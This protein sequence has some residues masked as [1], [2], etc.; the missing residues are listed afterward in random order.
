MNHVFRLVWNA[1][2]GAWSAAA[3]SARRRRGG[4]AGALL[5]AL[6]CEALALP[7]GAQLNAGA[8]S[9]AGN[10]TGMTINQTSQ[11]MA[12]NWQSFNISSGETV[13]F[14][15]PNAA[16][17][18]LNRVIGS[19]GSNIAGT[20]SANGQVWLINPNGIVFGPGAQVN[21]GAL[22][23]STLDIGDA[24]FLAGKTGFRGAGGSIRNAG[25]I[26]A[27]DGGHV[28]LLGGSVRNDGTISARLGSVAL[29]A[30]SA[31][32][33]DFAGDRLLNVQVTQEVASALANNTGS[34][35][36]D[37][38]SVLLTARGLGDAL[39]G[40][41]NNSGLIQAQSIDTSAGSIRLLASGPQDTVSVAGT[42]DASSAA[43]TSGGS[44]ITSGSK[45][46]VDGNATVRTDSAAGPDG[47]WTLTANAFTIDAASGDASGAVLGRA[48]DNGNVTVQTSGGPNVPG[49]ILVNS[50]I[51]WSRNSKLTLS[52]QGDLNIAATIGQLRDDGA[53]TLRADNG[54]ACRYDTQ[55]CFNVQFRD[56]GKIIAG[57]NTQTDIYYNP[58]AVTKITDSNS[59]FFSNQPDAQPGPALRL[60]MLVND[61]EQLQAIST[62]PSAN[63]ALGRDIDASASA[64]WNSGAG[65]L[66][67]GKLNASGEADSA[68]GSSFSGRLDGLGHAISNL[69]IGESASVQGQSG[70]FAASTS[71]AEIRNLR[72]VDVDIRTSF[73]AALIGN[74]RGLIDGVT[75][76][77]KIA[78]TDSATLYAG[79]LAMI[80]RGSIRNSGAAVSVAGSTA[81]LG[82]G[83]LVGLNQG[84]IET[85]FARAGKNGDLVSGSGDVG[86][87]VGR[88]TFR[89]LDSQADLDVKGLGAG[90]SVVNV[91]GLV[92]SNYDG[93]I[94]G[95]SASGD[96]FIDALSGS[97]GALVGENASGSI[98]DS[99]ATG[100]LASTANPGTQNG[101]GLFIGGLTGRNY[102]VRD[103]S[104]ESLGRPVVR[105]SF[106]NPK[107]PPVD[108]PTTPNTPD[109]PT[110][111]NTP[112][113]P[114]T[115][116]FPDQPVTPD[117][118][119]GNRP[120]DPD[121]GPNLP[122]VKKPPLPWPGVVP[123]SPPLEKLVRIVAS[124][125]D[126]IGPLTLAPA[127]ATVPE[128]KPTVAVLPVA[129]NGDIDCM[130]LDPPKPAGKAR[131]VRRVAGKKPATQAA[132]V[133][134]K[135]ASA[136]AGIDA[137]ATST[138][139]CPANPAVRPARVS[140]KTGKVHRA[141]ASATD[142]E[143][144]LRCI[145][146]PR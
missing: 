132:P 82:A 109:T 146:L 56:Q 44:I 69:F 58:T 104:G 129:P 108:P 10:G 103:P 113:S 5:L 32:T 134:G 143:V 59:Y 95:S 140:A 12:L 42:L 57:I 15:Q 85:S 68:A 100:R 128:D 117:T 30:G 92:G 71:E 83:G 123:A 28:A 41:V 55:N 93:I 16:A 11:R 84:T 118:P 105:N 97:A 18:A 51:F 137:P 1:R 139:S 53:I 119:T 144:T 19:S 3:E 60:W 45:L 87:L 17:I 20:L 116:T 63:Y 62:S 94:S 111:P 90:T 135:P 124:R 78:A 121:I 6:C 9:V 102:E 29:A 96:V 76:S 91:G 2:S 80:N 72:L 112:P 79:G 131:H 74:N 38:G 36:A 70:L 142:R 73:A 77:G 133:C 33:L 46:S 23:A 99:S 136:A 13:Q 126:E 35:L 130:F 125:N 64:S 115:P 98:L 110:T 8:G 114:N 89:V 61:V 4:I 54:G 86:G 48:L 141:I 7:Q 39:R 27:A 24:D 120:P 81:G 122:L 14:V 49:N 26:T 34:I 67:I 47:N 138:A 25:T 145:L 75:V 66:S 21:V 50:D 88:N 65:F 101:Q 22:V 106:W 43:G 40:A 31:M 107:P 127:Q 52:A 37:G